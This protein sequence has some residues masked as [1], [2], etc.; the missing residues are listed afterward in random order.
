LKLPEVKKYGN[1][2]HGG[3]HTLWRTGEGD[4]YQGG[5]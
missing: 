1:G 4:E 3:L 2:N 5:R